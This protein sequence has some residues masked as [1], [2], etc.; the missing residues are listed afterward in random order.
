[1]VTGD[2][3]VDFCVGRLEIKLAGA[4]VTG[5]DLAGDEVDVGPLFR[6]NGMVGLI[7]VIVLECLCLVDGV[8]VVSSIVESETALL[9]A[10]P[11]GSI[12]VALNQG[13][14]ESSSIVAS[15]SLDVVVSTLVVVVKGLCVIAHKTGM[16]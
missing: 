1:M 11:A 9:A 3:V 8:D 14:I 10:V 13:V 7:D 12:V 5:L 4:A 2:V 6:L 16:W 15:V